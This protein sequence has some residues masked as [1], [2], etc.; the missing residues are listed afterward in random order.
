MR[1]HISALNGSLVIGALLLSG[2]PQ[3][4]LSQ[5]KE[6]LPRVE[7]ECSACRPGTEILAQRLGDFVSENFT[8]A[9]SNEGEQRFTSMLAVEVI[10]RDGK[11][12]GQYQSKSVE[13][14]WGHSGYPSGYPCVK[15]IPRPEE[16]NKKMAPGFG[17]RRKI[18]LG[19]VG[20]L[21]VINHEERYVPRECGDATHVLLLSVMQVKNGQPMGLL[22]GP[23]GQQAWMACMTAKS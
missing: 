10:A 20:L 1:T 22:T 21:A 18:T 16:M 13:I 12:A 23:R 7:I 5:D 3:L 19:D 8:F 11:V 15:Y 9:F 17:E 14:E 6:P 4:A 2:T